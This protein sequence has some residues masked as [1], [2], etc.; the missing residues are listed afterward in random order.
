MQHHPLPLVGFFPSA[1]R[2]DRPALELEA[3]SIPVEELSLPTLMQELHLR[4]RPARWLRELRTK[5]AV[6]RQAGARGWT[7]PWN[8]YGLQVFR[9]H[10]QDPREDTGYFAPLGSVLAELLPQAPGPYRDFATGLFCDPT[11]RAFTFYHNHEDETGL[12][13][14]G[15]TLSF[16]R[17][18]GTDTSKHDRL[19]LILEDRRRDGRV[20]GQIDRLRLYISPWAQYRQDQDHYHSEQAGQ[21][22]AIFT[23]ARELYEHCVSH[24]HRWKGDEARQW[25][26]ASAPF[27]DH[28]KSRTFIPVGTSFY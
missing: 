18:V 17:C 13:H 20:D 15:L 26:H 25:R 8:Q 11:L 19:D 27:F 23:P 4:Q 28:F 3:G 16:G 24:Y 14:E 9:A 10:R 7:R 1:D 21:A 22:V 2:A 6:K 5:L 12:Q